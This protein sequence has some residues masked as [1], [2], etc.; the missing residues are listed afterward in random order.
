MPTAIELFEELGFRPEDRRRALAGELVTTERQ[1]SSDREL[2]VVMAFWVDAAPALILE[3]FYR[4]A[5]Y[6]VDPT[7]SAWGVL[8]GEASAEALRALRLA[9][10]GAKLAR[11]ILDAPAAQ[12]NLSADEAAA[13]R[14]LAGD[15]PV[16][17]VEAELR[18]L[19]LARY[20]SYRSQ[21]LAGIPPYDR[22]GRPYRPSDD[23]R[24]AVET[25]GLLGK[26]APPFERMILD[27]PQA[28][29][30]GMREQ[31]LW[32]NFELDGLPTFVLN[33]RLT[34]PVGGG[35]HVISERHF[36]VSRSHNAVQIFG[37]LLPVQRGALVFYEN[38]TSTDR[39][40]GFGSS[41]KHALGRKIMARQIGAT[42]ETLRAQRS[43]TPPR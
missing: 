17:E 26:R 29:V 31:F 7:A 12:L 16:A 24:R 5:S 28:P 22:G 6:E 27:Y 1:E 9:P 39:A 19:L 25:H 32:V 38:R 13:F 10:G 35:I 14:Q 18:R 15:D 34:A 36:Y 23:L 21:G 2:T 8:E 33:H 41:A 3:D 40:A 11:R 20:R 42:F 30:E 4:Q 37:G 43:A